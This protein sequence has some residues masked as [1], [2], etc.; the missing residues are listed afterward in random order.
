MERRPQTGIEVA[1]CGRSHC[2]SRVSR[3]R[4]MS[5][6]DIYAILPRPIGRTAGG[7]AFLNES[8]AVGE[9][10]KKALDR[11]IADGTHAQLLQKWHWCR[12]ITLSARHQ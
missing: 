9:S 5:N 6:R 7:M 4:D 2:R 12:L 8:K 1:P 3:I 10:L 11:F